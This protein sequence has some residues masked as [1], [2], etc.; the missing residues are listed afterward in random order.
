MARRKGRAGLGQSGKGEPAAG[1]LCNCEGV[2]SGSVGPNDQGGLGHRRCWNQAG[3]TGSG[4]PPEFPQLS[5][6]KSLCALYFYILFKLTLKGAYRLYS[7][8]S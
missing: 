1:C 3:V 4:Q 8:L 7:P 5:V 2:C 6:A